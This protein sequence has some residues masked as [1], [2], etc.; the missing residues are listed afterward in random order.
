MATI[1]QDPIRNA[2]SGNTVPH[3]ALNGSY[4]TVAASSMTVAS[5]SGTTRVGSGLPSFVTP[6]EWH[7]NQK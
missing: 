6:V 4:T 5:G 3:V 1:Y 2:I 7:V